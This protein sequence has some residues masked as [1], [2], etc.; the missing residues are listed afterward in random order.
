MEKPY[1]SY[2]KH[3]SYVFEII[4]H[5]QYRSNLISYLPHISFRH[6]FFK[7]AQNPAPQPGSLSI[8]NQLPAPQTAF[9][10]KL[11]PL[12]ISDG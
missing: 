5:T 10:L 8:L 1:L 6:P 2:M 12:S 9:Q 7:S 11:L 3:Y 4:S